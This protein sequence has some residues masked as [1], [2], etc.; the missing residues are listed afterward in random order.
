[1]Q[2]VC[3]IPVFCSRL[4][5]FMNITSHNLDVDAFD[6]T[7]CLTVAR[8][9]LLTHPNVFS[10]FVSY[11]HEKPK[12]YKLMPNNECFSTLSFLVN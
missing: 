10:F 3:H 6:S 11:K 7:N 8:I 2:I 4:A 5:N 9:C 12:V 1:M